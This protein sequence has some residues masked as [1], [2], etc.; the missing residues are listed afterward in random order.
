MGNKKTQKKAPKPS[1]KEQKIIDRFGI[2]PRWV[3]E[4]E[5]GAVSAVGEY[6]PQSSTVQAIQLDG[7]ADGAQEV[8]DFILS[9]SFRK[10]VLVPSVNGGLFA[11]DGDLDGK[12]INA[13]D[14]II[15]KLLPTRV[16]LR[17]DSGFKA[18]Y[19]PAP[20]AER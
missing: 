2:F 16:E 8:L 4:P 19:M 13:G 12:H 7:T 15:A 1:K 5:A 10:T 11:Y 6:F 20:K 14:W 9:R 3:D 17:T 18:I